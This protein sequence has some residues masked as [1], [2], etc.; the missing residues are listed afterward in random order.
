MGKNL[1]WVLIIFGILTTFHPAYA[2]EPPGIEDTVV[3]ITNP[4]PGA[5]ISGQVVVI[6]SAGHLSSFA[7]Y[8]L[9]FD[10]LLDPNEFWIPIGSGRVAQQ[11]TE[12]TLGIWD[13]VGTGI[14][15][16]QYQIRLRVFLNDAEGSSVEAI[17]TNLNLINSPPTALPTVPAEEAGE[18]P[19]ATLGPSPTSAIEQPPTNEPLPTIE[20]RSNGN[21]TIT[22]VGDSS[23][24]SSSLTFGHI[25][26]AFC[27][28]SIIAAIFFSIFA[29]YLWLRARFRPTVRQIMWQIR[30]ELDNE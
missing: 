3:V 19:Q 29:G 17:V 24:G 16:G 1:F 21:D 13:T 8:E 28:G 23:G 5:T 6:G 2:Q 27:T 4:V 18:T 14:S 10:N 12:G 9:E 11:V 20:T 15:D 22:T 26:S 25:Q 7:Y 30:N